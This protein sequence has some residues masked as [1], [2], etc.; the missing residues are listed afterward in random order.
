MWTISGQRMVRFER[1]PD[2]SVTVY[3]DMI[4]PLIQLAPGSLDH[5]DNRGV[6]P[7]Q[8][9]QDIKHRFTDNLTSDVSVT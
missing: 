4:L 1:A 6:T 3:T 7:R 2:V 8:L 5:P 9:L